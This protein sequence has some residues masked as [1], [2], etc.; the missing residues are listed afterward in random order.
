MMI[1]TVMNHKQEMS[2]QYCILSSKYRIANLPATYIAI[3]NA[4]STKEG[5]FS[6]SDIEV[7][8]NIQSN[9]IRKVILETP[10]VEKENEGTQTWR[11]MVNY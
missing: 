3:S 7:L 6:I 2:Q 9:L 1:W 4:L 5:W 8:W 10:V 11:L